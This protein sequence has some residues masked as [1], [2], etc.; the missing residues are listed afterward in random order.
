M[1]NVKIT[2]GEHWFVGALGAVWSCKGEIPVGTVR[3]IGGRMFYA[4]SHDSYYSDESSFWHPLG[5]YVTYTR[6]LPVGDKDIKDLVEWVR[7]Y[8]TVLL[9][10]EGK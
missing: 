1:I 10:S 3:N 8:K 4:W 6:W 7:E 5:K 2:D 9:E